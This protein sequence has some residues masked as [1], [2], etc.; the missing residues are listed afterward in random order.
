MITPTQR[1]ATIYGSLLEERFTNREATACGSRIISSSPWLLAIHY[2]IY[3][4]GAQVGSDH[5][6]SATQK[7]ARIA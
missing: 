6:S 2:R 3:L 5:C 7:S 4:N 1:S